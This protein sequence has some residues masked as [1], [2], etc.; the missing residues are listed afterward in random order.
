MDDGTQISLGVEAM[1]EAA[2]RQ[3]QTEA[4]SPAFYTTPGGLQLGDC[5][6]EFAGDGLRLSLVRNCGQ[7]VLRGSLTTGTGRLQA[8]QPG[9]CCGVG[10]G[11]AVAESK[12]CHARHTRQKITG[13]A[14][15]FQ[16]RIVRLKLGE[17]GV[18]DPVKV[19]PIR[20]CTQARLGKGNDGLRISGL[21]DTFVD[22]ERLPGRGQ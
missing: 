15:K 1:Y 3:A 14:R 12:L 19:Q 8:L 21:D 17:R 2:L 9:L 5:L 18:T 4:G 13:F 22:I 20:Q 7:L 11:P 10:K 16:S 6:V